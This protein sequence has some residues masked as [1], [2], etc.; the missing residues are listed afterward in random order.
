MKLKHIVLVLIPINVL[1]AYLVYNSVSSELA[2]QEKAEIRLSENIQKLK[3]LR[4]LQICFKK[5]YGNYANNFDVLNDFLLNDSLPIIRAIGERPDTLTDA[6]ALEIGII[7][8]DTTFAPAITTV[9]DET[10]LSSRNPNYPLDI[11]A[12]YNIPQSDKKY[13]ITSGFVEKGKVVVQVFEI[14]AKYLDVFAGLDANNRGYE[15]NSLIKVG[16]M[17]EASLNGNWGE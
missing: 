1:L 8:R 10:Y 5:T 3:D 15:L 12:L 17:D 2:F 7:T 13:N 16:S 4:Q 9:F 14:S 11:K 6:Q